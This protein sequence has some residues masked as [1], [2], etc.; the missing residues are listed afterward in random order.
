MIAA[1][2]LTEFHAALLV[3]AGAQCARPTADT[4]ADT[5]SGALTDLV[6]KKY[7]LADYTVKGGR[8]ANVLTLTFCFLA[9]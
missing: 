3:S 7:A 5:A 1:P 8:F 9:G 4:K 2:S 6:V